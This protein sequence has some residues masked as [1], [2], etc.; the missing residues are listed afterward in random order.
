MSDKTINI[1]NP[2]SHVLVTTKHRNI[3]HLDYLTKPFEYFMYD[4]IVLPSERG[5]Q[6]YTFNMTGD[7]R[8]STR[9]IS[10]SCVEKI[11]IIKGSSKNS[12]VSTDVRAFK[13]K[14]TKTT[15]TVV[16]NG[17]K[18]TCTCVGFQFYKNCKHIKAVHKKVG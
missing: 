4:G 2:G 18:Y 16:K 3:Y 13:V 5:D 6:P 7:K 9:N 8:M 11:K 12:S 10:M 17:A 15:Y 14:G 1:P